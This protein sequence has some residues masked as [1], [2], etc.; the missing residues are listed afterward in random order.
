MEQMTKQEIIDALEAEGVQVDK[1]M[2]VAELRIILEKRQ[3]GV[4]VAVGSA[5]K[6][7]AKYLRNTS[8]GRV[9]AATP[10]L[11]L[12]PEMVAITEAE[13]NAALAG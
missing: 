7:D 12:L 8:N 1:T 3:G 4:S 6:A 5:D 10:G 2:K 9:F 11:M 13:Y